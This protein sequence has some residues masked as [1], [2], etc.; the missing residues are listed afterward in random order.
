MNNDYDITLVEKYF[1]NE[2]TETEAVEFQKRI[3][4]DDSFKQLVDQEK[5]LL[6]GIRLDGLSKDLHYLKSVEN[7][8]SGRSLP[9][10]SRTM[11]YAMAAAITVLAIATV[12]ILMFGRQESAEELFAKYYDKPYL[13]I[14]EVTK[15]G[16]ED[17]V[18]PEAY[19][20]YD[21]GDYAR[22]AELFN[23]MLKNKDQLDPKKTMGIL[24]LLGNANLMLGRVEEA[25]Q[26]FLT[27]IKD[28]DD[29]DIPAKWFLSLCY[30]RTGDVENARK[31][32]KELGETE[33]TYADKAKELLE[34]VDKP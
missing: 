15:R 4:S 22:A 29:L 30:L 31:V 27:L 12:G 7:N 2:L 19:R 33:V 8:L 28:F 6:Q 32:L 13:N 10:Q 1:D 21:A 26:N 11:W 24:M 5:I 18:P 25:K 3:H 23:E 9:G 14:F 16:N 34:K 17:T 20:A